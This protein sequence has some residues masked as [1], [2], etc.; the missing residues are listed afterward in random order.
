ME[1]YNIYTSMQILL[2]YF[3]G[4][5]FNRNVI[6]GCYLLPNVSFQVYVYYWLMELIDRLHKNLH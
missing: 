2:P 4:G 3:N 1:I 6:V 5:L